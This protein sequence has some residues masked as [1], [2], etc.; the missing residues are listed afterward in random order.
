[1]DFRFSF[2]ENV[3]E[4]KQRKKNRFLK[5]RFDSNE[6]PRDFNMRFLMGNNGVK[7]H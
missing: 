7:M 5:T 4:Q 2:T 6:L 1:M 3:N